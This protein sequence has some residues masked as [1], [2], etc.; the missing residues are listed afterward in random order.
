[1]LQRLVRFAGGVRFA[2]LNGDKRQDV[3]YAVA[4]VG[5]GGVRMLHARL[6][7]TAPPAAPA[8]LFGPAMPIPLEI[9]DSWD[10]LW[11]LADIDGDKRADLVH[12]GALPD[13][14]GAGAR[15][16]FLKRGEEGGGFGRMELWPVPSGVPAVGEYDTLLGVRVTSTTRD[17]IVFGNAL[18][19]TLLGSK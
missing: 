7:L 10:R 5:T 3:V 14:G 13:A 15:Y 18:G 11:G 12:I 2:D 4:P 17:D 1:M 8:G 16:V 6:A 9:G 19:V